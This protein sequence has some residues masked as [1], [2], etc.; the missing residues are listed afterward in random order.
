MLL[1]PSF[2]A[3]QAINS[4]I[5]QKNCCKYKIAWITKYCELSMSEM[6]SF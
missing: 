5:L 4:T 3:Q 1:L 6:S 2:I